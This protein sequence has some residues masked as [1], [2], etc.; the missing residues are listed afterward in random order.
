MTDR[1][2]KRS[3][4]MMLGSRGI[5]GPQ[6]GV[7]TH[8]EA[9][10]PLLVDRGWNV[11]V[12]ARSPYSTEGKREWKGVQIEPIWA[13]QQ[14]KLE[15]VVHTALGVALA[16]VRRPDVVHIHAIGPALL[17]PA[18]RTAGLRTVVTHHGY[19]YDREKWGGLAK[20]MLRLGERMGMQWSNKAIAVSDNIAQSM[21]I[22]YGRPMLFLPNGVVMPTGQPDAAVLEQFGL[23]PRRYVINVSRI[24]PEKKQLDLIAAYAK[25]D[26]P[27]FKLVLV[28]G[29][30]HPDPYETAVRQAAAATSGVVMT[31]FQRGATLAG[32][33]GNAGLFILPSSHEGMPI[34]L[35]EALSY[36]LPVL[37]SD[38][39]A[40]LALGMTADRYFPL[41]D[42]AAIADKIVY[43]MA[44]QPTEAER[45]I[46][47]E[48]V[49][50]RF[51]WDHVADSMSTL[52]ADLLRADPLTP[53]SRVRGAQSR[54]ITK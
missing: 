45:E 44:N 19:D 29:A 47:I 26:N 27:D 37:A 48:M 9:L 11:N 31:G 36:G 16:S 3:S 25:L 30:D 53:E 50:N 33:F 1:R 39:E 7:E 22:R 43:G 46:Q 6:G 18:A 35:L 54:S 8:I 51:G 41:G 28:G 20:T 14:Q 15:A 12:M 13:P 23:E 5:N 34:A 24:V 40:N 10:A 42:H 52:Y 4:I 17:T 21:Q 2:R 49:R 38:I 32:L